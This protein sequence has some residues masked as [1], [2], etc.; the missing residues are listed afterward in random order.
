MDRGQ[1]CLDAGKLARVEIEPL[2]IGPQC[3]RSLVGAYSCLL[4][5]RDHVVQRRVVRGGLV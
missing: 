3:P 1:S 2:A 4:A 5:K